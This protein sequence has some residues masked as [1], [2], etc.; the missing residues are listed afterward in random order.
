MRNAAK[1]LDVKRNIE[2]VAKIVTPI[3]DQNKNALEESGSSSQ[4]SKPKSIPKKT[5]ASRNVLVVV[6]LP[7]LARIQSTRLVEASEIAE[8]LTCEEGVHYVRVHFRLITAPRSL[9]DVS[10]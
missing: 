4:K 5:I 8:G 9:K 7:L 10:S 1:K 3:K 6:Q 2:E